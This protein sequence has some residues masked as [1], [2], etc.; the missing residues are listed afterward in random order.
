MCNPTTRSQTLAN[1][2]IRIPSNQL[3]L[4]Y[5]QYATGIGRSAQ[6]LLSLVGE[7]LLGPCCKVDI[8]DLNAACYLSMPGRVPRTLSKHRSQL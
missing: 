7:R 8:L 4:R 1:V 5:F 2:E 6:C 3:S